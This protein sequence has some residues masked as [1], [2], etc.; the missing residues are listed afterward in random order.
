MMRHPKS[1]LLSDYLD[2][3]LT[4]AQSNTLEAHLKEC[5]RC[6]SLLQDLAEI[7]TRAR[8]LPD[9]LPAKD[10]W[11]EISRA[12]ASLKTGEPEVIR[13]HP[14]LPA[15]DP[16]RPRTGTFRLSYFQAAA[17]A[18]IL[19]L[20]SGLAGAYFSSWRTAEPTGPASASPGWVE[21][22]GMEDP[23]LDSTAREV[24]RLEDLLDS[25][26][27]E[28]DPVT[29][30]LLEK[31]LEVIDQAIRE[32]LQALEADPGNPFLESHLAQAVEAKANYLRE[33]T[34]FVVPAG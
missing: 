15:V 31:N 23:G 3:E 25:R 17:A 24:A 16:A 4:P 14:D 10:L 9:R 18:L 34:A 5:P 13:L 19:T 11:P 28:L 8:N 21:A 2:Q 32:S 6:A 1:E 26:K 12:M 7:Q 22:A 33:A 30:R 27:G 29:A 20:F